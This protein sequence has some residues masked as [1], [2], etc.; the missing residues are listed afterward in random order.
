[1]KATFSR[2]PSRVPSR[3]PAHVPSRVQ[4][5]VPCLVSRVPCPVSGGV[6][7]IGGAGFPQCPGPGNTV[8][9]RFIYTNT[10]VGPGPWHAMSVLWVLR[11]YDGMFHTESPNRAGGT[12]QYIYIYIYI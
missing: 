6:S 9:Y 12:N 5:R 11:S 10:L 1:M 7:R 4:S 3:I 8:I 2:V